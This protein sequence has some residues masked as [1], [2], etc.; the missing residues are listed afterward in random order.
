MKNL[1]SWLIILGAVVAFGMLDSLWAKRDAQITAEAHNR[2][3]AFTEQMPPAMHF[4]LDWDI[5]V[6]Q[7]GTPGELAKTRFYA[8]GD[9]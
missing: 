2:A 1:E 7:S 5:R 6:T 9:K 3:H 4:P 8:R